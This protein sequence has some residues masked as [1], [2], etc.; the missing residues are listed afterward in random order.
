MSSSLQQKAQLSPSLLED[1]PSLTTARL[2]CTG[3]F[4]IQKPRGAVAERGRLP[5]PRRYLGVRF[6]K[7]LPMWERSRLTI[8][9][10]CRLKYLPRSL[11]VLGNGTNMLV[12]RE[13]PTIGFNSR[14]GKQRQL[15]N[16]CACR[17][18]TAR[19]RRVCRKTWVNL[20]EARHH[21]SIPLPKPLRGS[22]K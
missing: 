16:F 1:D 2:R 10:R 14:H 20:Q 11:A 8:F 18:C 9:V 17:G 3:I 13:I 15:Y 21:H 22:Q 4:I 12:L 7:S 6:R 19:K 5:L